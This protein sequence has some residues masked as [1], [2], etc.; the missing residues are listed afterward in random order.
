MPLDIL[1]RSHTCSNA[2]FLALT[3]TRSSNVG[4]GL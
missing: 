2:L 3:L 1:I 4:E